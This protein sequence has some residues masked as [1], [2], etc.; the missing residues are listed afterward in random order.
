MTGSASIAADSS[1]LQRPC[2]AD[3]GSVAVAICCYT[4]ARWESIRAA[5]TAVVAQLDSQTDQLVVVVDHNSELLELARGAFPDIT[6]IANSGPIGLSGAR[7]CAV[8]A[9]NSEVIAFLDDDAIP[10]DGWVEGIRR[11]F[12]SSELVMA[13]GTVVPR[14]PGGH[15][16]SWFPPEFDWVVGCDYRGIAPVGSRIRNPIGANMAVRR[17]GLESAGGFRTDLGRHRGL[18]AG[19]EETELA[20]RL[21]EQNPAASIRRISDTAVAHHVAPV[22]CTR[23]YFLSRCL[24]EGRSKA[25]MSN[26]LGSTAPLGTELQYVIR[27]LPKGAASHLIPKNHGNDY[28]PSRA[29]WIGMGLAATG[30]GWVAGFRPTARIADGSSGLPTSVSESNS[31]FQPIPIAE[32]E[33][34]ALPPDQHFPMP[35]PAGRLQILALMQGSPLGIVDFENLASDG[36]PSERGQ[37][38]RAAVLESIGSQFGGVIAE[39]LRLMRSSLPGPSSGVGQFLAEPRCLADAANPRFGT[40]LATAITV[41]VCSIGRTDRLLPTV[42]ALLEQTHPNVTILVVDNDPRSGAVRRILKEVDAENVTVVEEPVRGV[43]HA[44]NAGL[45]ACN[46]ELIAFTDDDVRPDR[47]WLERLVDAFSADDVHCIGCVTGLVLPA[48]FKVQEQL[49]FEQSSGFDKGFDT[50]VWTRNGAVEG[51]DTVS[52]RCADP[53][54]RVGRPGPVYPYAG[55]EFGSGNNMAFRTRT[56]REVGGFDTLLGTGSPARG[57]EDLDIFR[58][59]ILSGDTLVYNPA[60]MV[61]HY[62]RSDYRA[63]RKQMYDY[64]VGMSAN[65]FRH[66]LRGPKETVQILAV[67]PTGIRVLLDPN[68]VKNEGKTRDH[69]RELTLLELAGYLTGP[70]HLLWSACRAKRVRARRAGI[71]RRNP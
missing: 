7:N 41:V 54:A 48:E 8:A 52:I 2:T 44:R 29:L 31:G 36:P 12:N 62:H 51:P 25:T 30:L 49:W 58:R 28:H 69:P 37:K 64:G 35:N 17:R 68:S 13:G 55:S 67:I 46:D 14:W 33:L 47:R 38:N 40:P 61:W 19:C 18:P 70:I 15:R 71:V 34:T 50:L 66:M 56:L 11:A 39:H 45:D 1:A 42:D 60:A 16:P 53:L 32:L 26:I 24:H 6:V 22:R 27:T 59:V 4:V 23:R 9:T 65:L 5:V 43:S 57:G 10:G 3:L 21:V 63:L 20:I